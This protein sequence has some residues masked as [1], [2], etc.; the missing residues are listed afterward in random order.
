[1]AGDTSIAVNI[2]VAAC[3]VGWRVGDRLGISTVFNEFGIPA[4][5]VWYR[6]VTYVVV[7]CRMRRAGV[8]AEEE[9][10]ERAVEAS[11]E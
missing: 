1:M 9:V 6:L 7:W 3:N 5:L 10:T 4:D 11:A 8:E 2:F